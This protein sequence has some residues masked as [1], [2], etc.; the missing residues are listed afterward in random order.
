MTEQFKWVDYYEEFASKLLEY[1][2]NRKEL[3]DKEDDSFELDAEAVD[4]FYD[5]MD[6]LLSR[7]ARE[8]KRIKELEKELSEIRNAYYRQKKTLDRYL[9]AFFIYLHI[10]H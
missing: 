8:N 3:I 1:R 4:E 7:N 9:K 2:N 10:K 6:V 5:N